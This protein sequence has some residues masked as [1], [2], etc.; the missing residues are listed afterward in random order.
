[1]FGVL[2]AF[3]SDCLVQVQGTA[4]KNYVI[5]KEQSSMSGFIVDKTRMVVSGGWLLFWG[6][7]LSE[8]MQPQ[9]EQRRMENRNISLQMASQ[10]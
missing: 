10:W 3:S 9:L 7:C 5:S 2:F 8:G 1:M 4:K 6:L